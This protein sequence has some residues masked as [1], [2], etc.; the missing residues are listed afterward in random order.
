MSGSRSEL[1]LF[2]IAKKIYWWHFRTKCNKPKLAA[3]KYKINIKMAPY[4]F[5]TASERK[6]AIKSLLKKEPMKVPVIGIK[7]LLFKTFFFFFTL[8]QEKILSISGYSEVSFNFWWESWLTWKNL[9]REPITLF[10]TCLKHEFQLQIKFHSQELWFEKKIP[11]IS[12][13]ASAIASSFQHPSS[14]S[15][16]LLLK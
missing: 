3:E 15:S 2:T 5:C 8:K 6:D 4:N 12:K 16:L 10:F 11:E 1:G 7:H 14:H 13:T 9:F